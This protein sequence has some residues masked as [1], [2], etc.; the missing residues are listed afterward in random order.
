MKILVSGMV[1]GNPGQGGAAWAVLQYV[2]GL[3]QLGHDVYLVEPVSSG[4]V[5]PLSYNLEFSKSAAYF[6]DIVKGFGLE[7]RCGLLLQGTKETVGLSYYELQKI[8]RSATVLLNISG[9]LRQQDLTEGIPCR[10]YL[11]LDPAF[12][13]L[14]HATQGIDMHLDAHNCFVTVGK[15]LGQPTCPIPTCGVQW[16]TTF[17]P[18]V[19]NYWPEGNHISYDGFTTI[20]NWRGYGS[21]HHDGIFYGQKAH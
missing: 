3:L 6:L 12:N 9:M 10:V 13:Q 15:A 18:V 5:L 17:Q 2:L 20:G 11:D 19:F 16:I 8:A 7:R 4:Q 21:I 14:W 1:A